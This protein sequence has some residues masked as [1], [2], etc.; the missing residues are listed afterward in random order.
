MSNARQLWIDASAGIAGDMLLG[1]LI[2]AGADLTVVQ[3]AVDA[4]VGEAV[5]LSCQSVT[6]AG[7]HANRLSVEVITSDVSMREW[8]VIEQLIS[9]ADLAGP[10]R[11]RALACFA[12]LAEAEANVHHLPQDQVHFHEVGAE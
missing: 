11:D 12:R 2:D 5:R 9:T 6:R 10:V 8:R 1:A 7:Q 3:S 4:V